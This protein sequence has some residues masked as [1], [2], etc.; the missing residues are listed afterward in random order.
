MKVKNFAKINCLPL[1]NLLLHII[2]C[3]LFKFE[4]KIS[5][6]SC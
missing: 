2:P 3:V 4:T 1:Q 5:G 6:P